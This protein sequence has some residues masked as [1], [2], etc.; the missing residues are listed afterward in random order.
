MEFMKV[1]ELREY[2]NKLF[3][4]DEKNDD[5]LLAVV[6]NDSSIGARSHVFIKSASQGFDWEHGRLMMTVNKPIT[7]RQKKKS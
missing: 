1:K 4:L 6:T 2:L 5:L 3:E 7:Q